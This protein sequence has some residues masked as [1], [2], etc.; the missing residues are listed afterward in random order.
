MQYIQGKQTMGS[1]YHFSKGIMRAY[2]HILDVCIHMHVY[3]TQEHIC[4]THIKLQI[5]SGQ[6]CRLVSCSICASKPFP[7]AKSCVPHSFLT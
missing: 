1:R 3:T 6:H 7:I 5:V 2:I 4:A